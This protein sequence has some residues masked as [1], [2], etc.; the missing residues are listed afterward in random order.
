MLLSNFKDIESK[1][2]LIRLINFDQVIY[3]TRRG[4]SLQKISVYGSAVE[5]YFFNLLAELSLQ[6]G[7]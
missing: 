4:K 5:S 3:E 7:S 2:M 6:V 1:I